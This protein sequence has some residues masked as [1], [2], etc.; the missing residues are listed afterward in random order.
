MFG[1]LIDKFD[2]IFRKLRGAGK[3]SEKNIKDSLKEVRRALLEADVNYKV[4]KQFIK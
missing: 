4:T 1:E 2:D 3:L